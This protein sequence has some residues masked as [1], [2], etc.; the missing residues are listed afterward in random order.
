MTLTT[1]FQTPQL[2]FEEFNGIEKNQLS[3]VT[4]QV[5]FK[6]VR[7]SY[8]HT[9]ATVQ[10]IAQ[11]EGKSALMIPDVFKMGA[12]MHLMGLDHGDLEPLGSHIVE[13]AEAVLDDLHDLVM[14]WLDNK[15]LIRWT[16]DKEQLELDLNTLAELV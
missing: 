1:L 7:D 12:Q 10:D 16:E 6:F 5:A 13:S 2:Q 14:L 15:H 8:L 4:T 11:E 3:D 9:L